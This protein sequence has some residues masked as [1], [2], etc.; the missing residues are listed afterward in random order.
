MSPS[1]DSQ[2]SAVLQAAQ[3]GDPEAAADLVP[4]VYDELRKLA[5]HKLAHQVPGQT[6]QATALVHETYLRSRLAKAA[7]PSWPSGAD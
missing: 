1:S 5:A 4:L 2:P 7:L 3:A 6:L